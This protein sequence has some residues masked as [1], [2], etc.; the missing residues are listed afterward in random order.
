MS[1]VE[2]DNNW[3]YG[4]TSTEPLYEAFKERHTVDP[5]FNIQK[6]VIP[7]ESL[8]NTE[9]KEV[10][11]AQGSGDQ[12]AYIHVPYCVTKCSFCRFFQH[13][14]HDQTPLDVYTEALIKDIE[15]T[16]KTLDGNIK[17]IN[18]LYFGGGTPTILSPKNI[19]DI[20][21]SIREN[22]PLTDDCE[23]TFEARLKDIAE[24]KVDA[25][26]ENGVNRFSFGVQSF[27]TDVR[28]LMSRFLDRDSALEELSKL[29]DR[30][31]ATVS[32]DLVYGLPNQ[33]AEIW[34]QDLID[35]TSI[36]VDGLDMYQLE[37]T[38]LR[39]RF[40]KNF[41]KLAMPTQREKA[42]MY[43]EG[44]SHF[45]DSGYFRQNNTHWARNSKE[46]NMYTTVTRSGLKV[47]SN[48]IIAF[49]SGAIGKAGDTKYQLERNVDK[50][51]S[52]IMNDRKPI[53]SIERS[54]EDLFIE[55][56]VSQV[57]SGEIN[58]DVF[59]TEYGIDIQEKYK[60]LLDAYS[61]NGLLVQEDKTIKLTDAGRFWKSNIALAF[62]I[63][64]KE[65]QA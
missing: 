7:G 47:P 5:R 40:G 50:Y 62:I 52:D 37:D 46:R 21:K 17:P 11:Q 6:E 60:K 24:G 23:I 36:P 55:E 25:G 39:V 26:L 10:L 49:G 2:K 65:T 4:E 1:N 53:E 27:N 59:T 20:F 31:V 28:K 32:I 29:T 18:A 51:F 57:D 64:R 3:I 16:S 58:L 63:T 33:S 15:L 34:S 56:L 13:F 54:T 30:D 38:M 35:T 14:A 9:I 42:D 12:A 45:Q 41:T 44:V 61:D 43:A 8:S 48:D 19:D 22:L